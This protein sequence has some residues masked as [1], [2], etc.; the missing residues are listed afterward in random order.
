[1]VTKLDWMVTYLDFLL[2][3]MSYDNIIT[4]FYEIA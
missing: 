1:M 3:I 4:W 2:L